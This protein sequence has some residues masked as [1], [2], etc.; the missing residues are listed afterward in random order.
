L[1][2]QPKR[3]GAPARSRARCA[4]VRPDRTGWQAAVLLAGAALLCLVALGGCAAQAGSETPALEGGAV[5]ANLNHAPVTAARSPAG[6]Q[7]VASLGGEPQEAVAHSFTGMASWY[8][9]D[10]H[11][12]LTASGEPYDMA[13]LTAA[14][15]TLPFGSRV[16]VTN[17]GNGR[18]VVVI[19]N[20][21]GPFAKDRLIDLSQAAAKR[22]GILDDGVAKVRLDVLAEPSS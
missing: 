10:F 18:S 14:H 3:T 4:A 5:Q 13:A 22:I 20:D 11:G 15:Q 19:I 16:R 9:Q 21:R 2:F 8:G 7:E 17:L 1:P 12:R 6:D